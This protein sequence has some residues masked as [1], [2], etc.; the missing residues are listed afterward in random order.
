MTS[1]KSGDSYDVKLMENYIVEKRDIKVDQKIYRLS[2]IINPN[3]ISNVKTSYDWEYSFDALFFDSNCTMTRNEL[4]AFMK[5]ND[6][7]LEFDEEKHLCEGTS[8]Y[9][10]SSKKAIETQEISSST[11]YCE[12]DKHYAFYYICNLQQYTITS[13][14]DNN[15][16]DVYLPASNYLVSLTAV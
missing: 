13:K 11:Q 16:F 7:H 2:T 10:Y 4:G 8:F 5:Y 6:F 9:S 1:C 15:S 14:I 3:T 12:S